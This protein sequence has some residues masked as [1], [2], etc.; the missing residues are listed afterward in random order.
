MSVRVCVYESKMLAADG[1]GLG[2]VRVW[3]H[4]VRL[5]KW[6]AAPLRSRGWL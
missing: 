4:G 1:R 5:D 2:G 3:G 6:I